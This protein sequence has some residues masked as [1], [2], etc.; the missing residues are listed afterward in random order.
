MSNT[1]PPVPMPGASAPNNQMAVWSLVASC[2]GLL[3]G[4][5]S[6]VGIVLGFM[7]KNQIKES[8]GTQGGDGLATAG[9]VIGFLSIAFGILYWSV[10]R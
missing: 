9:I 4:I 2:V 5:G 8:G 1:P 10:L 6:I 3:C 7:A